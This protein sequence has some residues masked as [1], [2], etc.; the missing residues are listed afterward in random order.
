[1]VLRCVWI[2][3]LACLAV[4]GIGGAVE[5]EEIVRRHV[6]AIGGAARWESVESLVVRGTATFGSFTWVWK[7]PD[8]VRTEE[9][10]EHGSGK[11]LVTA[12]DGAVGWTTNPFS[13]P[14][15]Q[16]LAAADLEQW[17]TG[18]AIRS[19]LL[20]LPA[21]GA[22]LAL[23]G[24]EKV[25]GRNAYKLSLKRPG[26]NEVFL[27]IDKESFLLVQRARTL[28]APWGGHRTIATPLR[29]YR[30]VSGVMIPHAIGETRLV[31][32]VNAAIDEAIFRPP[33][34]LR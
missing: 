29:D 18:V 3:L 5:V 30:R 28:A 32:E 11:T 31:T 7:A 9:R 10:D 4:P 23:L 8:R 19:D 34:T 33:Q 2:V 6:E 21:R 13:N 20:D 22:T 14:A 27:W 24:E 16:R 17:H 15:P 12:F 25:S 1:M 26:R